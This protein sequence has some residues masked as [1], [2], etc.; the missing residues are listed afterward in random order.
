MVSTNCAECVL[1]GRVLP[2]ALLA[3]AYVVF[4]QAADGWSEDALECDEP[5][6]WHFAAS[7]KGGIILYFDLTLL[8]N[9]VVATESARDGL[10]VLLCSRFHADWSRLSLCQ[11]A[12]VPS[13]FRTGHQNWWL[14]VHVHVEQRKFA[15]LFGVLGFWLGD[16][17]WNQVSHSTTRKSVHFFPPISWKRSYGVG[18]VAPPVSLSS[19]PSPVIIPDSRPNESQLKFKYCLTV[20]MDFCTLKNQLPIYLWF[21]LCNYF[22]FTFIHLLV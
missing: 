15:L 5:P 22:G 2:L 8:R 17:N 18:V 11:W 20:V 6:L 10:L 16:S 1:V 19:S 14:S 3:V 7:L 13:L 4:P 9:T 12:R 21:S